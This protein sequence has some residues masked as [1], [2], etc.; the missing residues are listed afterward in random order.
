MWVN[1]EL[2]RDRLGNPSELGMEV[3][4]PRSPRPG[5]ERPLSVDVVMPTGMVVSRVWARP[6]SPCAMPE[7]A[8]RCR[9]TRRRDWGQNGPPVRRVCVSSFS[10]CAALIDLPFVSSARTRF[11]VQRLARTFFSVFF[12]FSV[13][14][15]FFVFWDKPMLSSGHSFLNVQSVSVVPLVFVAS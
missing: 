6:W 3:L 9:W 5:Q 15:C 1:L 4:K 7:P 2:R 12:G 13:L 14:L 10:S 8:W 11:C